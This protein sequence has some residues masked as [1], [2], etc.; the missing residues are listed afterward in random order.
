MSDFQSLFA[1]ASQL[2]VGER[3]H[4]IESLWD[5][6]PDD[7]VPS[8]SPEWLAEI[9]R[10]SAEYDARLVKPIPWETVRADGMRLIRGAEG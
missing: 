10:R 7:A 9:E 1:D 3:L 8:L 2:P 6:L 4:L 5:T